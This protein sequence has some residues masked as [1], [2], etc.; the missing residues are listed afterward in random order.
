[1]VYR[2]KS[3]K[4]TCAEELRCQPLDEGYKILDSKHLWKSLQQRS[5]QFKTHKSSTVCLKTSL[6]L[7]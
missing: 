2:H 5:T 7:L 3:A 4:Y 6:K 1:M